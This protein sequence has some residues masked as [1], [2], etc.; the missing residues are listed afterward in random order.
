MAGA[1]RAS[2]RTSGGGKLAYSR[3]PSHGGGGNWANGGGGANGNGSSG[4]GGFYA[5]RLSRDLW[6][7]GL[8][9]ALVVLPWSVLLLLFA[10]HSW[11]SHR[12]PPLPEIN[13]PGA[14]QCLGWRETY[15]CHPFA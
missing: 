7:K 1:R 12:P 3:L 4:G 15:F 5:I 6:R 8:C 2:Y 14:R 11:S 13:L 10:L 9:G